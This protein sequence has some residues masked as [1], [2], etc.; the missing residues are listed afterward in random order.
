MLCFACFGVA[1]A[2]QSLPYSY[3]FENN[4]LSAHGWTTAN[5]YNSNTSEFG[6]ATAAKHNGDYGF[7]F[8]S[9]SR[10]TD[11]YDQ[12]LFSPE[13]DGARGVI[14]S[15]W[16][17][18]SYSSGTELFK[19]GYSTTDTNISSFTW[20]NEISTNS[21]SWAQS[22]E[23]MF[24][25]GTKYVAIWYYSNYQYRLFVDDFSFAAAPSCVR[26]TLS[27]EVILGMENA[28]V[29]WTE[30]G[31]ATNWE[32]QYS[33]NA[34]FSDATTINRS[35]IPAYAIR[36]LSAATTYYARVRANCGGGDYSDWSNVISF[37]TWACEN[38]TA[39]EYNLADSY[40]D[41]W[42]GNAIQI[43]DGCGDLVETLT[44]A[45]GSTNSGTLS[46]CGDYYQFVWHTGSYASETSFTL[47]VNG[48]AIYSQ[49]SGGSL[50]DGQVL[51]TIGIQPPVK[52]TALT[53]GTPGANE[54]QLSW[55][56]NGTATTWQ[57]CINDDENNLVVANSNP[58][59]LTGLNAL[60]AY[61]VK[62]R[63]TDGTNASCW[64]NV[65]SFTTDSQCP[66]P[67]N[68]TAT[69]LM[70][71]SATLNWEGEADSYNV[72]YRVAAGEVAIFEDGFE[73]GLDNWTIY[74]Q[75][76]APNAEGWV[77]YNA[78]NLENTT[79]HSG[80][81]VV[82][83]WSWA[84]NAY[85]AD[86][87][88]VTPQIDLQG[89]LKF[90]ETTA[91]NWPDSY[92]VLL[93]TSGNSISDF[94][95]TLREM[96]EATGDWS[97]V[98]IDLSSYAGQQGYIAIHHVSYDANYLFIDDFGI[99]GTQDAG[100][101]NNA[102][103]TTNSLDITGLTSETN[104]VFQVQAVCGTDD[105]SGWSTVA[106]FTT[107]DGCA[108]PTDLTAEVIGNAAELSWTGVQEY[109]NVQYRE[110]DPTAPATI[111]LNIP[112]DVWG[113]GSGYQMLIDADATAYGTTIP[114][115]GGLTSSG[116]ASAETYAE[117][118]YKLPTNADGSCTTS[119]ILVEGSIST[120]IPAG[121]YDWCITNPTPDDR[122]WI[123]SSNGNVSGRQDDY[124]FEPGMTYE[125]T[126]HI[127]GSSDAVDVTITDNNE[128]T[129]VEGVNNP[130]TLENLS[131]QTTY[132]YKVQGVDCDGNGSTTDWSAID[133]FTTG[134]FYTKHI[135]AYEGDGGYYL[136]AS[137]LANNVAPAN[138]GNMIT[139]DLGANATT[140]SSTYDLYSFNQAEEL[141]W[142]NYRA[143]TFELVNGQ[144]YLYASK[145]GTELVFSGAGNSGDTQDVTLYMTDEADGLDFPDWNLVGNPFATDD[146][147][148]SD[149]RAFYS[150]QNSGVLTPNMGDVAIGPMEGV[151][152]VANSNEE[153]LTFTTTQ[154]NSKVAQLSLNLTKS[155]STGSTAL[156]DRAIVS[157]GE[158]SQL[159]KLQFRKGSA[160]VFIPLE[161]KDY[162]V[163]RTENQ[164][165][166]PVSFKAENNGTYT[167]SFSNENVEF[168][169][170]H[171]I[172]NMTG[173]DVDLLANP[174]YSF[175]A[176]AT[177][178]ANRFKL[179]FSNGNAT[180]DHFAFISNGELIVNGEGTLRVFDVLGRSVL[181]QEVT[182][183]N[184]QL[185]TAN[186]PAGVYMIQLVNGDN[187]KTQK[188]VVK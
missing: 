131:A 117:F 23:F 162:A 143:G 124:V 138:V 182:T 80:S 15:F 41:G 106:T 132:K 153:T 18:A 33:T 62:V 30:N 114:E 34:D 100:E 169:Y 152:V 148:L 149:S 55:T 11:G 134:E 29:Q 171:L 154:P 88:L 122:I 173:T 40:G 66:T 12:Y 4:D 90:W 101:W 87:W 103:S 142:R 123:A 177:D 157:F 121:T 185:S 17:A 58:F 36:E 96:Q 141:E 44:I 57:I 110:V 130:Y 93:S 116:D 42:N 176:K 129:L 65:V 165:E 81:Y 125:F 5:P 99:Y 21:T 178:Y 137:P 187:T 120:E 127:S 37:T 170:L 180:D 161:G 98:S 86:N 35:G 147:Y 20:G 184:G 10:N 48:T 144:G 27:N 60:T 25:T 102:T 146:A 118:E 92:E 78:S 46:L 32:L 82:S 1:K 43:F 3:G 160:Q 97:E 172:D 186:F 79:N 108:V 112:T 167:M 119:N 140:E 70:P 22:E 105:E 136:I 168:S 75:G 2:Q 16:Y 166:M 183:A 51:H 83:A 85:N 175:E 163:V 84:S 188:I 38:A 26:P 13:L 68:L 31:T 174:S 54:V 39:V 76:E 50:T 69:N 64:S 19:V 74:T 77:T 109:Y 91:G 6:I 181:T 150:M 111:I 164:G 7:R 151:F 179:V 145:E 71:T 115:T 67:T 9:Y 95:I 128:W 45:S 53:A 59:T 159:P 14:L 133:T 107:P 63:S 47:T 61:T 89:T 28:S 156:L 8:S 72:R 104:Y 139:D 158:G 24:P 49:Q 113:D 155:A 73:N 52:P 126:I 94:T 56:E 135:E